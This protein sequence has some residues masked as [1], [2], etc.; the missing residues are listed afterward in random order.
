MVPILSI[1]EDGS[2]DLCA[3]RFMWWSIH[4]IGY[5]ISPICYVNQ[6]WLSVF[7]ACFFK[8]VMIKYGG[9]AV[10]RKTRPFFLGLILGTTVAT[11]TWL[12]IDFF[13]GMR[14]NGLHV[15]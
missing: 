6:K 3:D 10:F 4:R 5:V 2:L 8:V 9:A 11:E 13:T 15:L 12:L 14:G 7:L 1:S